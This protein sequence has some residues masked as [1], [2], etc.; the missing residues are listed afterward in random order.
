[1][2][3]CALGFLVGS[4]IGFLI[5]FLSTIRLFSNYEYNMFGFLL[6]S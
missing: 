4:F 5:S 6:K 3:Y 2:W 1:V